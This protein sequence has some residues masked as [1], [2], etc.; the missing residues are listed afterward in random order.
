VEVLFDRGR[1]RCWM[2]SLK[3]RTWP[4]PYGPSSCRHFTMLAGMEVHLHAI[5]RAVG[6]DG[7]VALDFVYQPGSGAVH[8]IELNARPGPITHLGGAAGADFAAAIRAKLVGGPRLAPVLRQAAR[9][10]QVRLFPQDLLRSIAERDRASVAAWL[11]PS[12][13]R[14]VP[15][16]DPVLLRRHLSMLADGVRRSRQGRSGRV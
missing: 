4:G 10:R 13:W 8:F 9:E 15:W 16:D 11:R 3:T 7:L 12:A 1:P 2:A 5:G 6:L 14:D